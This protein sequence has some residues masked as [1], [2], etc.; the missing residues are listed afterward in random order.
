MFIL[1]VKSCC[2]P[3]SLGVVHRAFSAFSRVGT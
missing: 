1:L 3:A 2:L